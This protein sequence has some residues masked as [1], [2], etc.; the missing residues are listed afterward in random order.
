[1]QGGAAHSSTEYSLAR[2]MQTILRC[3]FNE[4]FRE[5]DLLITPTTPVA[6]PLRGVE[7]PFERARVLGRF[8]SMF[9]LTGLPALSVPCGWTDDKLPIGMQLVGG[10]WEEAKVLAAG[11]AYEQ[12]R[13]ERIPIASLA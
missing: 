10:A 3:Q 9:N 4:F 7:D 5:F 1:L 2:R 6:A 12:A 13:G 8:T 11:R